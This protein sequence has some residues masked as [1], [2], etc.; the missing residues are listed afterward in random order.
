MDV[1]LFEAIN[2]YAGKM[3]WLDEFM[4]FSAKYLAVVF[5]AV[6]VIFYLSFRAREQR[7]A[8]LA[9]I[10]TL[11]AL[12]IAQGIAFLDP[13]PRPYVSHLA[14]LLVSRSSDPSFPSDHA[15][16]CFA[17]A[18]MIWL[19][20]RKLGSL[21]LGAALLVG[22][23]RVYVGVHYPLDVIGGAAL[24]I[25]ISLLVDYVARQEGPHALLDRLFNFL[26][27]WRLAG[28]PE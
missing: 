4:I 24:G 22:I 2:H 1:S 17:I 14:D 27:G 3:F 10:A 16:F 8:A 7:V 19:H 28:K 5:A 25:S 15:T 9:G 26:H 20:H 23:S 6:L 13:R 11:V 12:G 21:L 18:M